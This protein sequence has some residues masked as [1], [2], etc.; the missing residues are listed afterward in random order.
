MSYP[1]PTQAEI[2]RTNMVESQLRPNRVHNGELLQAMLNIPREAFLPEVLR[3][4]AYADE[5]VKLGPGRYMTEPLITA[6]LLDAA[7]IGKD[8][9]VLV[10]GGATA[11]VA[12]I[13]AQMARHVVAMEDRAELRDI[14]G[15]ALAKLG[16]RNVYMRDGSLV[17]GAPDNGPFDVI[18]IDGAVADI[19][20]GL[21]DQLTPEGRL[22]T[23]L[24]MKDGDSHG[25]I[26]EHAGRRIVFD[27]FTPYLP[28][29]EPKNTFEFV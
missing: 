3:S 23:V 11:Y 1:A 2:A 20:D 19:P 22:V 28:G 17:D 29:F 12:A 21:I 14:G 24:T 7:A 6:R 27:G 5:A 25:M 10:I 16:I 26:V 4:I 15:E 13:A 8:D 9:A 18:V